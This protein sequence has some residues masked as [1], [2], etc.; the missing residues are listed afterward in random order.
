MEIWGS[1]GTLLG[2]GT[3]IWKGIEVKL[4]V[5]GHQTATESVQA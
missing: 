4:W 5:P 3:S 2:E 1:G